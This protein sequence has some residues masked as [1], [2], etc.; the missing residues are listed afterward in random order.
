MLLKIVLVGDS[1]A[2]KSC[3]LSR[4]V[5]NTFPLGSKTTIGVEFASKIMDVDGKSIKAQVWDT[6]GQE[7]FRSLGPAFYRG[8]VA[9]FLVYDITRPLT[10]ENIRKWRD[11]LVQV[12]GEGP[13]MML[14][15]NKSDLEH[16]RGVSS[17]E[18]RKFAEEYGMLFVETSSLTG[19]NTQD[20]FSSLV[21]AAYR[22][23]SPI[24]FEPYID[25]RPIIRFPSHTKLQLST[26]CI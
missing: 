21:H 7:R 11:E 15:G 6:A 18:G 19:A 3:L 4:F 25:D 13:V 2:G 8:A 1:T 24:L 17:E 5:H 20:A 9:A 23:V 10:F 22:R 16:I 26:C 12:T 14:V